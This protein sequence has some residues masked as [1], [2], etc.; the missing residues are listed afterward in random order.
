M[1]S[2]AENV[3][4]TTAPEVSAPDGASW[5]WKSVLGTLGAVGL[6]GLLLFGAW[7]KALDPVAFEARITNEGLDFLLPAK[8]VVFIALALE[9]GLGLALILGVRRWPVLIGSTLLVIFFLFLTGRTYYLYSQGLIEDA[10]G[11]GC[12]GNLVDR[13]P[14]EAFWQDLFMMVPALALAWIGRRA[15]GFP[16]LRTAAIAVASTAFLIFAWKSPDL[17]IDDLATRLSPGVQLADICGGPVDDRLCLDTVA[18]VLVDGE[19]WV[20]IADLEQPELTDHIEAINGVVQ[21]GGHVT[22][23][24]AATPEV[25]RGFFWEWGPAFEVVEAPE[26]LLRPLYRTMPR[27]FR[28]L[29]GV[30]K[31][32]YAGLP[33][34]LTTSASGPSVTASLDLAPAPAASDGTN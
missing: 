23:L 30:V 5:T 26:G 14:A 24:A 9:V 27:S 22:V 7:A 6:G 11:C 17:P 32:T 33:P 13:T 3:A 12:F 34:E 28:S 2:G 20:I 1:S 4:D 25:A 10:P 18:P 15:L 31:A 21:G 29:D 16:T 8:A 19:H